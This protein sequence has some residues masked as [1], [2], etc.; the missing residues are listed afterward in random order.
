MFSLSYIIF[1]IILIYFISSFFL[2]SYRR[3]ILT[4]RIFGKRKKRD[5]ETSAP[6]PN[7]CGI[8]FLFILILS[9]FLINPFLA[10]DE[11]LNLIIGSSVICISGFWDDLKE[12]NPYQKLLYQVIAVAFVVYYNELQ[13]TNLYG[14][15]G[16]GSMPYWPGFLFSCFIGIFMINSFNLIDGIDGLAG[17]TSII[18]FVSFGI[19]FWLLNY[20]GYFGICILI[21]GLVLG[22][23]PYNFNKIKKVF[24]GDSGSMLIGYILFIMTM[25]VVNNNEP[26][27][28]RLIDRTI[29]PIAP[30]VIFI[31]PLI[32]T[33]SV[34]TNRLIKGGSPFSADR[35]HVH[36]II[37]SK[38][39]SHLMTSLIMNITSL[40]LLVSFSLLAFRLSAVNF[41]SLFFIVFFILVFLISYL[42]KNTKSL[43]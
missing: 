30:M 2:E 12:L 23:L 22:Y 38:T 19:L 4:Y 35:S 34:Y 32:D 31:I 10:N 21:I 8:V 26:I 11:L 29:L 5:F 14:F 1:F 17:F 20:K 15:L 16:I 28:D 27:I 24:M 7:S 42:R 36:H 33:F 13:I 41:I 18:S 40:L 39:N 43:L 9:S 3:L 6:I 25:Q 37:L